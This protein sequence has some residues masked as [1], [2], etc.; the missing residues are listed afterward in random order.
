MNVLIIPS[1]YP[2]KAYPTVGIF[3]KI[4]AE[5]LARER[6]DW[7][8]G[9]SLWGS[10][11]P[12]LWLKTMQPLTSLLKMSSRPV[13]KR[14]EDQLEPNCVEFF[15]PAFT[16][17]RK[18]KEGNNAGIIE[19]NKCNF[20]R[21]EAYFGKIDIIH[22][23]VSYP[24]GQIAQVLSH[25]YHV[26]YMVTEHMSPFPLPSFKRDFK[27]YLLPPL[28]AANQVLAVG[29]NLAEELKVFG[30]ESIQVQNFIDT[31][32]FLPKKN[33]HDV[34]MLFALGRLE[35][36]KGFD[37]LITAMAQLK[38]ENWKLRI[39]GG[40]SQRKSLRQLIEKFGLHERVELLGELSQPEVLEEMQS[41]N[42]FVLS[43]KH[44]SSGVVLMEALS[45]GKPVVYTRCG[46]ITTDL[47]EFVGISCET[48]DLSIKRALELML[49]KH[50][51]FDV[52]K[53]REFAIQHYSAKANVLEL[54][55][56]YQKLL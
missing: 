36:Q 23:H 37:D 25:R 29:D 45:C 21:M 43:S 39:G 53:I 35:S 11:E 50:E 8:I 14:Y 24:A 31:V 9:I 16:W 47:P 4:Q 22:A 5:L 7:N 10:H 27:K 34:P 20:E 40:G 32:K 6:P 18:I 30:I 48:M 13:L 56:I 17:T 51:S 28:K 19:A 49:R 33:N 12:E 42:V 54:E 1:W 3:F 46:G 55:K 41:C 44:E 52:V 26:P 2:S 38:G 15:H